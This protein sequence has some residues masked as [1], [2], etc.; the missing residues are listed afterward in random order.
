[1]EILLSLKESKMLS[2]VYTVS[3]RLT[4]KQDCL[5]NQRKK[6]EEEMKGGGEG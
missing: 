3:S 1:M 4:I 5:K 6:E 2:P